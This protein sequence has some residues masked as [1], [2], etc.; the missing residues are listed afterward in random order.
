MESYPAIRAQLNKELE[1][2]RSAGNIGSA[3]QAEVD[4]YANA[5]DYELLKS[6]DDDLKF[7]FIVSRATLHEDTS[8]TDVRFEIAASAH[9]KCERCW[10]YREDVNQNPEHSG[11]CGR[12]ED[13]LYGD[14]EDRHYA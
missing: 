9:E 8:T 6:L 14:G 1:D 7:V 2:V 12:C 11:I 3:L 10:H 4:V 13:N 5:Q